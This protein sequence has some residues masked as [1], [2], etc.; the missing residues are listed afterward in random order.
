[1]PV[2]RTPSHPSSLFT[3]IYS[4]RNVSLPECNVPQFVSYEFLPRFRTVYSRLKV[5]VQHEAHHGARPKTIPDRRRFISVYP[6]YATFELSPPL[7]RWWSTMPS[8]LHVPCVQRGSEY[9]T[10]LTSY[11]TTHHRI[12]RHGLDVIRGARSLPS[13]HSLGFAFLRGVNQEAFP[14][15]LVPTAT[16]RPCAI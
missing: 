6:R 15:R 16:M 8:M 3:V 14:H 5:V 9:H 2:D 10:C 11:G 7:P 12:M 13:K 1:M 4:I